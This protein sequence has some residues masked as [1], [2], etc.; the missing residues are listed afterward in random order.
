MDENASSPD[1]ISELPDFILHQILSFLPV[2]AAAKTCVISKRWCRIW[3]TFPI[4]DCFQ[5][6]FGKYLGIINPKKLGLPK[7]VRRNIFEQRVKF[8]SY[9]DDKLGR[10]FENDICV[11]KFRLVMT[12]VSVGLFPRVDFWMDLVS[13]LNVQELELCLLFGRERFYTLP[14]KVLAS[15]SLTVLSLRGCILIGCLSK[16]DVKFSSLV[17]LHLLGSII[18]EEA[19]ST[20]VSSI[21]SLEVL[22][23]K[24]C[25]GF[26]R[27]EI[28]GHKKLKKVV[29]HPH[30]ALKIKKISVNLPNLEE[31]EVVFSYRPKRRLAFIRGL[32]IPNLKRLALCG[33]FIDANSLKDMISSFPLLE[34]LFLG[35]CFVREA[36]NLKSSILKEIYLRNCSN[37][38]KAEFDTPGLHVLHVFIYSGKDMSHLSINN[39]AGNRIAEVHVPVSVMDSSWFMKL[40]NFLVK[41]RF[42]ELILILSITA[43]QCGEHLHHR[44]PCQ[45][46]SSSAL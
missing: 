39:V 44:K 1:M 18:D 37:A 4:V 40:N 21:H 24:L 9:I 22:S 12:L 32:M 27:L 46:T 33:V 5:F 35:E 10:I 45:E 20:L 11:K 7:D 6:Y 8:M 30:M 19:I 3:E 42:H 16:D 36:A 41:N 43:G 17:E 34:R 38:V 23:L 29:Y 28:H 2:K 26:T 31:L 13:E 25:L 15:Q 14:V